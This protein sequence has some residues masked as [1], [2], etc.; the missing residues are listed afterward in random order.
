[1]AGDAVPPETLGTFAAPPSWFVRTVGWE[2]EKVD[3]LQLPDQQ[4][5]KLPWFGFRSSENALRG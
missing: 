2:L 3:L 4:T 5:R 1:V